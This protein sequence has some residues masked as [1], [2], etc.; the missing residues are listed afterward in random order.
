MI[1]D[2]QLQK[3]SST[4]SSG[5]PLGAL[6][7]STDNDEANDDLNIKPVKHLRVQ[8]GS[9]N[10][11]EHVNNVDES[12]NPNKR[13][14]QSEDDEDISSPSKPISTFGTFSRASNMSKPV[15]VSGDNLKQWDK[16]IQQ[17]SDDNEDQLEHG[18]NDKQKANIQEMKESDHQPNPFNQSNPI[19][20]PNPFN[21]SSAFSSSL[22]P[23][24]GFV[25]AKSKVQITT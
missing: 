18:D 8:Q 19:G 24:I 16:I 11:N 14:R 7:A 5:R 12:N 17:R 10:D 15:L 4:Q 22:F 13:A 20:Q 21:Q 3:I 25:N 2:S 1:D 6:D 9:N 23:S